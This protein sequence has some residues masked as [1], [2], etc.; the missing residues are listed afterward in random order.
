MAALQV[1]AAAIAWVGARAALPSSAAITASFDS[2]IDGPAL[3]PG[4]L[5]P[6][7]YDIGKT[8]GGPPVHSEI[9]QSGG[10]MMM[11]AIPRTTG[12]NFA[13]AINFLSGL[14]LIASPWVL[15]AAANNAGTWGAV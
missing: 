7:R 14:W 12:I 9:P 3:Q 13:T 11:R 5:K 15:G 1:S 8:G 2:S 10:S 6:A 4:C